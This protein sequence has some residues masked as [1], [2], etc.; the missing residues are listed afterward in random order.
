MLRRLDDLLR[1]IKDQRPDVVFLTDGELAQIY[2]R[3]YSVRQ[4]GEQIVIRNFTGE[5]RTVDVNIPEETRIGEIYFFPQQE[6]TAEVPPTDNPLVV[7]PHSTCI[8]R[9]AYPTPVGGGRLPRS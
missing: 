4:F 8:I 5:N 7:P 1:K 2:N 9:M 3:G 6:M